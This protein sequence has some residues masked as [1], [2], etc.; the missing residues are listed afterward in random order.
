MNMV[1]VT[2][3]K[4]NSVSTNSLTCHLKSS[5]MSYH[6]EQ[7]ILSQRQRH[8]PME[9]DIAEPFSSHGYTF[10]DPY[11]Y[12]GTVFAGSPEYVTCAENGDSLFGI[13]RDLQVCVVTAS[14]SES[15]VHDHLKGSTIHHVPFGDDL[16]VNLANGTCNV[17]ASL[18][19]IAYEEQAR[20][21]GYTGEYVVGSQLFSRD[22]I[23]LVTMNDY[24]E[25][26]Q[27]VIWV[28]CALVV[29]EALNITQATAHSFPNT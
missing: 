6:M 29:A 17:I 10:S 5:S 22:P 8:I 4:V 19:K 20:K 2:V 18:P 23:S 25:F 3:T 12:T 21:N 28:L 27:F 7:L 16:F 9:R 1:I 15:V 26:G 14:N 13:C 24:Y 11:F